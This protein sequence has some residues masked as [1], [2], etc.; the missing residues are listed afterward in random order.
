MVD[1]LLLE[2]VSNTFPSLITSS[3]FGIE[4]M[5][6]FPNAVWKINQ[7]LCLLIQIKGENPC[8]RYIISLSIL[9]ANVDNVT[10]L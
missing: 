5:I 1:V 8:Q 4:Q 3:P 6:F 9:S 2:L 10:R 7:D